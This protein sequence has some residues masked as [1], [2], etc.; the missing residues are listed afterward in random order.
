MISLS[1]T[2]GRQQMG[3][4]CSA[5]PDTKCKEFR[6]PQP[7]FPV[8]AHTPLLYNR[9]KRRFPHDLRVF[10][11]L[12]RKNRCYAQKSFF[13]FVR[14]DVLPKQSL[15]FIDPVLHFFR[16]HSIFLSQVHHRYRLFRQIIVPDKLILKGIVHSHQFQCYGQIAE[17]C[18]S[19]QISRRQ[20]IGRIIGYP[21]N[22]RVVGS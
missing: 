22:V 17:P 21:A 12:K 16:C 6:V 1:T 5:V 9:K 14:Y 11:R 13:I 4:N 10:F 8:T 20:L 18:F 19:E 15:C 2:D 3:I 7:R